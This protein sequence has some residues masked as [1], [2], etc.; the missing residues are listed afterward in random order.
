MRCEMPSSL[1]D[2]FDKSLAR[3]K[4]MHDAV[5]TMIE[6]SAETFEVATGANGAMTEYRAKLMKI[7]W[8]SAEVNFDLARGTLEVNSLPELVEL[9]F[10][11][12]RRLFQAVSGQ[13]QGRYAS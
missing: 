7:G 2:L 12:Q 8:A 1:F 11:H 3:A 9:T 13:L 6:H 5:M 10:I 4:G